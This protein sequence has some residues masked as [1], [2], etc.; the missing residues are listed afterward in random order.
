MDEFNVPVTVESKKR[1]TMYK[2]QIKRNEYL[3]NFGDDYFKFLKDCNIKINLTSMNPENINRVFE[4]AQRTNQMNFSGKRYQIDELQTI[5]NAS[6]FHSYVISCED[7]FGSYG[8]VGFCLIDPNKPRLTDLM[9]SCR[10]QSK[11]VEHAFLG[12]VLK[13]YI[14]STNKNFYANYTK[15]EKNKPSGN[16]FYDL[17]FEEV[18]EADGVTFLMFGFDKEIL[19]DHLIDIHDESLY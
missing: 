4:L 14:S 15:T 1:R 8:I 7:K 18:S 13:K 12:Y 11:R 16:V 17:G 9:F 10:V 2:Q 5:M 6:D 19:N 3:E